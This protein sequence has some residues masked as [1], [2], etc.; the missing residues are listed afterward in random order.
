VSYPLPKMKKS[1]SLVVAIAA[2][3]LGGAFY[4]AG[5]RR[6]GPH[7]DG[8]YTVT[9][10]QT[11]RPAGD[12]IAFGGRP[13]D[14][15]VSPDGWEA[16]VKDNRGIVRLDL[17]TGKAVQELPFPRDGGGSLHGIIVNPV[18]RRVWAS[19]AKNSVWEA[20]VGPD[21]ALKIAREIKIPAAPGKSA[22]Y[23]CG[24]ALSPDERT[25]YV[26]LSLNNTVAVVDL[27]T[28]TVTKEIPVGV[29]PYDIVL[30]ADGG[31]AWVSN[32]GGRHPK[33]GERT[34]PSG[35]T[36]TLV[37]ERG[38]ARSG[39]VSR[40]DLSGGTE[41]AQVSVGLHP[42]DL[43]LSGDGRTLYVANANDDTV[44]VVDTTRRAVRETIVVKPDPKLAFGS[45]PNGLAIGRDHESQEETL[46]IACGGSNAV[47]VLPLAKTPLRLKG[48]I[49]AGW[50]PGAL[51]VSEGR[52]L[53]A[54]IKGNGSRRAAG[55][56]KEKGWNVYNT[57]H[58]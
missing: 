26:C 42:S 35:G 3:L 18:G 57:N 15:V 16:Y 8:S 12:V 44:S 56:E 34:A 6:V 51:A 47:A 23:P 10:A 30:T 1:A 40:L 50:F 7:P 17:T 21:G 38:I 13:V 22:S 58:P 31:S 46:Y 43:L 27:A 54:N 2:L 45:M 28:G 25:L 41:T 29:A 11:V 24:L 9:T 48:W 37:D 14:M 39:T 55:K 19:G 52:L 53:I 5:P 49:P 32:W 20:E 36:E 4:L 33:T